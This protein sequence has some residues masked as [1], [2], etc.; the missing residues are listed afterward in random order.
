MKKFYLLTFNEDWADEHDVPALA[1]MDEEELEEWKKTK[2]SFH[3]NLG[4]GGE[5]FMEDE[6]GKTGKWFLKEGIVNKFE[7]DE[8]F[9]KIFNKTDLASLSLCNIFDGEEFDD[10]DEEDNE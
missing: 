1:V 9:V 3:A 8:S 2:L 10:E 4:N 6:Q 7:V 5:D